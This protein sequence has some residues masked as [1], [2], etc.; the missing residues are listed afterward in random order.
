M[1]AEIWVNTGQAVG[2]QTDLGIDKK[3]IPSHMRKTSASENLVQMSSGW[4]D[5]I[6]A[7]NATA[8]GNNSATE[9]QAYIQI[10]EGAMRFLSKAGSTS[11]VRATFLP[12]ML[13][14][15]FVDALTDLKGWSLW[16]EDDEETDSNKAP[17]AD[18]QVLDFAFSSHL[19]GYFSA[20]D[21]SCLC[22]CPSLG[23][24]FHCSNPS[25]PPL[26][27]PETVVQLEMGELGGA[28]DARDAFQAATGIKDA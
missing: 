6:G 28:C 10:Y 16:N 24:M 8:S 20:G 27:P 2:A 4:L 14:I 21:S 23:Y 13:S 11:T 9:N 25:L 1:E 22:P 17:G 7:Q 19:Y 5:R 15:Y 26:L 3:D 12:E 18:D